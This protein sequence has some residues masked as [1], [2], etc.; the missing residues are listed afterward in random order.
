MRKKIFA[1]ISGCIGRTP[2]VYLNL[3]EHLQ[4][5]IAAK[6]EFFNPSGSIKDRM[7]LHILN[8][9]E[10]RNLL[11]P[12]N[13]ILE[14]S[15]GNTGIALAALSAARGYKLILT[16]P[17]TVKREDQNLFKVFGA[18]IILTPAAEGMKGAL[19]KINELGEL[20]PDAFV[21]HQFNNPANPEAHYKS[22][23]LEIWEETKGKVDILVAGIGTGGTI[24]GVARF[25]KKQNPGIQV[26]G[27]EPEGSPLFTKG[28]TGEHR[29][30]GIGA[31]FIPQIFERSLVDDIV[32]VTDKDAVST[33]KL[34]A[35]RTGILSGISSGAAACAALQLAE[36]NENKKKLIVVIFPDKGDK[37]FYTRFIE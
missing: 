11:K 14:S 21:I 25:L 37:Y 28:I 26:Y 30:V 34:I 6:L 22:T 16:M 17:E 35:E 33:M 19:K 1:D 15:S 8:D 5:G 4:A 2:L 12:G 23:G 24:T 20:Y 9:A 3:K 7:I 29:I 27:V 36:K 18:E 10:K 32:R 31:G 13:L